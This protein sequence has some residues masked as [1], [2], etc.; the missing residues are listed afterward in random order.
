MLLR[1]VM[2]TVLSVHVCVLLQGLV[3]GGWLAT[4]KN[5]TI[6]SVLAKARLE[7]PVVSSTLGGESEH[8]EFWQE[9]E[10]LLQQAWKEWA[11]EQSR[12]TQ[13]P[14][15]NLA[16]ESVM[17]GELHQSIQR[18]RNNPS[19]NDEE[20][21]QAQFWKQNIPGVWECR[22]FFSPEGVKRVRGHLEAIQKSG[23]PMRRPNGMNRYGLVLDHETQG[24]VSYPEID[25]FRKWLAELTRPLGR[26]FFPEYIGSPKDDDSSYAFSIQYQSDEDGD[27]E[28]KEHSDASAF[29]INI[30][31]NFPGE[32][33][34]FEGSSL[35]F[36]DGS[37]GNREGMQM[38][39][40]MAVVHRGLHRHQALPI[41]KGQRRQLILWLFGPHGYVRFVP[42]EKDEQ[43]TVEQR[44]SH[45][46]STHYRSKEGEMDCGL[47]L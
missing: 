22:N 45:L 8:L 26:M 46:S 39:P 5:E 21:F 36:V 32:E 2:V 47:E 16:A 31:L 44:W 43:M 7:S 40:G 38:E 28:L 18:L 42:Y 30:N 14:L 23:I 11:T 34:I 9:H 27:V 25:F 17:D 35:V 20:A 10:D 24:G 33:D 3:C 6:S 12:D 4:K 1:P 13:S 29:T 19:I 41:M 37:T 15:P